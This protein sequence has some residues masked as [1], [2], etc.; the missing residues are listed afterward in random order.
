[1]RAVA[2]ARM[3]MLT[4]TL[5]R[6]DG[7]SS[8]GCGDSEN[9]RRL[10]P[11]LCWQKNWLLHYDNAPSHTSS[12]RGEFWTIHNMTVVPHPPYFSLFPRLKIRP[13][14][15]RSSGDG[16]RVAGGAEHPHRTRL[17]GRILKNGGNAGNGAC[18]RKGT[19]SRVLVASRPKV[20]FSPDGST[21]PGNYGR[22]LV[23][24]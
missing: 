9:V 10:R 22:L 13:P 24:S 4:L 21:S 19:T 15:W 18:S 20:S 16:G 3:R 12:F 23:L 6:D 7:R 17:P 11:E 8:S 1:M 2:T 5:K 14:F